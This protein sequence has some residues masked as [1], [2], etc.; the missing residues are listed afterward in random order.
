MVREFGVL[1]MAPHHGPFP[2]SLYI[3]QTMFPLEGVY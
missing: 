1:I 2:V 3:L